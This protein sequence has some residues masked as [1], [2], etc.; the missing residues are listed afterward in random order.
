VN[1]HLV[2]NILLGGIQW[3][4]DYSSATGYFLGRGGNVECVGLVNGNLTAANDADEDKLLDIGTLSVAGFAGPLD[5]VTCQY[6]AST[7]PV[8]GDFAINVVEAWNPELVPLVPQPTVEIES[9]QC[10]QGEAACGDEIVEG[11]E[12]CDDGNDYTGDNC[13][14]ACKVAACGDGFLHNDAEECDDGNSEDQDGCSSLC[15]T[16]RLC[17]DATDDGD[18]LASDSLRI[19][20][21][22]VGLDVDCPKWICDVDGVAGVSAVDALRVLRRSVDLPAVLVCGEP[23]G[24]LIRLTT[25]TILGAL[26]INVGY[27]DVAGDLDGVGESVACQAVKPGIDSV[28]NNKPER[29]FSASFVSLSGIFGPGTVARCDFTPSGNVDSEDFAVTVLD[30]NDRN[31]N[32]AP[33]PGVR[34]IPD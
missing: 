7:A 1:F 10:E 27:Q 11:D 4:T 29:I 25:P 15:E 12:Q 19:L 17:G 26:Q 21:R 5:L 22:A 34:A 30:A 13:P 32:P 23:T 28:F 33:K 31:G 3:E 9:L 6:K 20:L 14:F 2:E 16:E 18:L 8:S 24:L